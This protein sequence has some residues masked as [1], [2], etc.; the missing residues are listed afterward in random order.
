MMRLTRLFALVYALA[1][2]LVGGSG[3]FIA[4]WELQ[5]VFALDTAALEPQVS[6]TLLNQ[7]RFLKAIEFAAGLTCLVGFERIFDQPAIARLFLVLIGVGAAARLLA[8]IFDGWPAPVFLAFLAVELATF[9]L[10]G[11]HHVRQ[12]RG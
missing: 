11:L 8:I 5:N 2:T 4:D 9:V 12:A 3:V 7:Y 1:L 6:A 10:V